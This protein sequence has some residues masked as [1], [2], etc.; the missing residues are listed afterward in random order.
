MLNHDMR[1]IR[2]IAIITYKPKKTW[3]HLGSSYEIEIT[4]QWNENKKNHET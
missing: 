2:K 1:K 3:A 4:L